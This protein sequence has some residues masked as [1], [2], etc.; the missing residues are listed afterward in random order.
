MRFAGGSGVMTAIDR[1]DTVES[2]GAG[3][4]AP[5]VYLFPG[6]I[7]ISAESTLVSTILGSC[8]AVCLWDREQSIGGMNHFLLPLNPLGRS[9]DVRYG[10]TAMVRLIETM[11]ERGASVQRLVAKIVGGACVIARLAGSR[12]S[13]GD[14]NVLVAREFLAKVGVPVAGEQT[15]GRRGRKLFFHTGNGSAYVKDI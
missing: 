4:N 12:Q 11:V 8:V 10:D 3:E 15:G 7:F 13:I 9:S 1:L 14:Q 5:N 6:Q 2:A